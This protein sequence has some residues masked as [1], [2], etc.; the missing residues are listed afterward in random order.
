MVYSRGVPQDFDDWSLVAPGWAWNDVLHYFKKFEGMTDPS[1]FIPQNAY[2]HSKDG[3]VHVSRPPDNPVAK[4]VN[5]IMLASYREMGIPTVLESNGP[6]IYGA[7]RPHFTF[8]NGRRSSTAEAYLRFTEHKPNLLVAKYSRA[9]K[10]L[11][12]QK[13]LQA[14]GVEVLLSNGKKV[15]VFAKKEI[16]VSAGTIDSPKLLMLSGI[17]PREELD[18]VGIPTIVDLPVGKNMQEHVFVPLTFAGKRGFLTAFNNLAVAGQLD[19]FP[20]PFLSTYFKLSSVPTIPFDDRPQFQT[21]NIYVGA[22]ASLLVNFACQGYGYNQR[23]CASMSKPNLYREL[24]T[25]TLIL[26]HPLSRGR[27]TIKSKNPLDDPYIEAGFL[28]ERQDLENLREG[29]KFML[30]QTNTTYFRKNRGFLVRLDIPECNGLFYDSDKYWNCHIRNLV[31]AMLHA[32]GTCKMGPT[33]VVDERLKVKGIRRLRVIDASV[34]PEIASGNTNAAVMMIG[35]KGADMIK[36][37][38]GIIQIIQR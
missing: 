21:F 35:E 29:L 3:P 2:L 12:D 1:V 18:R 8:A 34:M 31:G 22:A 32:V 19:S 26:L 14:H 16:I 37:D 23:V 30:K 33:G 9:T 38:H 15:N 4:E 20:V 11:I 7:S 36:E 5:K 6:D 10:V 27:V 13:K 17:G 25:T 28:R 24:F